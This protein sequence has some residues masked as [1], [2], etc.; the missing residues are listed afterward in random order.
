[1]TWTTEDSKEKITS[2]ETIAK[3]VINFNREL[4]TLL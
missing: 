1:V 4:K 3:R 2:I